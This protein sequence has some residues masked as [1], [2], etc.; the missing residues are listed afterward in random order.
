MN[1]SLAECYTVLSPFL[2]HIKCNI[3]LASESNVIFPSVV[4][5]SYFCL[6]FMLLTVLLC[7]MSKMAQN[8]NAILFYLHFDQR[9]GCS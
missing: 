5:C 7:S 3:P 4:R 8:F 6:D 2:G 1:G 9:D